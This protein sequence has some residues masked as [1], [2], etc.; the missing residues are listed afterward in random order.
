MTRAKDFGLYD[1]FKVDDQDD[2][3]EYVGKDADYD[4]I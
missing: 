4:F 2:E 1:D 3:E